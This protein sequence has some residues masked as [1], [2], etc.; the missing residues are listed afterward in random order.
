Q[1]GEE[2]E[3]QVQALIRRAVEGTH[4]RLG[5]PAR[6]LHRILEQREARRL[7]LDPRL[8]R[9]DGAPGV[10]GAR[11]DDA[12]ELALLLVRRAPGL[13][14]RRGR[15]DLAGRWRVLDVGDLAGQKVEE[16]RP[17]DADRAPAECQ[18]AS[19]STP[20]AD[21]V[22]VLTAPSALPFH[23]VAKLGTASERLPSPR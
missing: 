13:L 19:V 14:R 4:R 5:E 1:L 17:D 22:D 16:D 12:D 6:R 20:A 21:V 18:G 23:Q 3:V 10:L 11:E 2:G 8:L 9:E 15:T 7:V